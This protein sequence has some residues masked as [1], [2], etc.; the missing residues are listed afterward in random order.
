MNDQTIEGIITAAFMA[1]CFIMIMMWAG[2][3][4]EFQH[5]CENTCK[6]RA[7]LTPMMGGQEVCF[8]DRGSG[9]WTREHLPAR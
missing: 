8:C 6:G 9:I 5:A 7:A 4:M 2:K 3:S 1:G